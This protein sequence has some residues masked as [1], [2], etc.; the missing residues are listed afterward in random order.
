MRQYYCLGLSKSSLFDQRRIP[1]QNDQNDACNFR[2]FV[3]D[4]NN[5]RHGRHGHS[6][7]DEHCCPPRFLQSSLN[8]VQL[9]QL[10]TADQ[11]KQNKSEHDAPRRTHA[12]PTVAGLF[13]L[14]IQ[15]SVFGSFGRP[16]AWSFLKSSQT[17]ADDGV[18]RSQI[19]AD[20]KVL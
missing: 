9:K 2:Q 14:T 20:A 6:I 3:A 18:S 12:E 17:G 15:I 16:V 10:L 11:K 1:I 5:R 8:W 13:S 7:S 4:G 19:S